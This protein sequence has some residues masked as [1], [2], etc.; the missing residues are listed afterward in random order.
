MAAGLSMLWLTSLITIL[1]RPL[2]V[3]PWWQCLLLI[4]IRS[5]LHTGLFII[6]H[7]AMHRVLWPRRPRLNDRLG[8]VALLL[9]AA[10]P[11]S[12]C[13][14]QHHRH[15]R[16]TATSADPDFPDEGKAHLLSW[17]GKFMAGY[18]SPGQMARLLASWGV[19][20]ALLHPF[21]PSASAMV[22]LF[23]TLP[24]LLSSW[25]LFIF[26][27]YLPH[28]QQRAPESLQRPLSLD[29]PTWLSL[30]AC[31]HFGYHREHHDHP[32][33][34]WY[35]LPAHRKS[36]ATLTPAGEAR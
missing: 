15:H 14:A 20:I 17:Y 32:Q 24:L 36:T 27:T 7:D 23:C 12:H 35:Q 21:N 5:Q 4:L 10:L 8:A 2:E 9:Y 22:L 11:Y 1:G 19:L 16:L 28:R 13:R 25:Q 31:Y 6:G 26:G 3:L 29:L 34:A 18:L 30:L 33:L